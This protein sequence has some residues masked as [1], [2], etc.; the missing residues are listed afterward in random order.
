MDVDLCKKYGVRYQEI[1]VNYINDAR[2]AQSVALGQMNLINS[3][4]VTGSITL[5]GRPE[6]RLGYPIYIEHRDAFYYVKTI[7]H[8]FDYGGS[9]T[10]T[11]SLET[12]RK[13]VYNFGN[14]MDPDQ[15]DDGK[16]KN[17]LKDMVYRLASTE[18][19]TDETLKATQNPTAQAFTP[20]DIWTL[21]NTQKKLQ[22]IQTAENSIYSLR[23][24]K[25]ILSVRKALVR[26]DGKAPELPPD[27]DAEKSITEITVPFTDED[28]YR[29]VGGF[30]YGRGLNPVCI[31]DLNIDP[32]IN[33]KTYLATMMQRPSYKAEADAMDKLFFFND[34]NVSG[35]PPIKEGSVP[36][37]ARFDPSIASPGTM[38]SILGGV[39]PELMTE[40]TTQDGQGTTSKA[41]ESL[42]KQTINGVANQSAKMKSKIREVPIITRDNR[43]IVNL[44]DQ[45]QQVVS[46]TTQSTTMD[47]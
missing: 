37:Y 28:G 31:D 25:Y 46:T 18:L 20:P 4:C 23:Q 8:S 35:N 44:V 5:P 45:A 14:M 2:L 6:M 16:W 26:T 38:P 43:G 19:T 24:G 41:Q 29:V 36:A 12:E 40:R 7:N 17:V 34:K 30:P 47:P 22:D 42:K 27:P 32:L 39:G 1:T 11:L 21:D 33:R 15:V 3:K 9:Y 10:T 13:K